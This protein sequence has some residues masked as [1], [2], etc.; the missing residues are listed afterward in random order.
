[1]HPIKNKIDIK[2]MGKKKKKKVDQRTKKDKRNWK[3]KGAREKRTNRPAVWLI[4][5]MATIN[6]WAY[7]FC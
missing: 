1:M 5:L 3:L 4:D 2:A 7:I 6:W